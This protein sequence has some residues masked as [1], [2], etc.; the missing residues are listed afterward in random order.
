M[1]EDFLHYL[2]RLRRFD[3]N[4][5]QT[6]QGETIEIQKVG[7]H[8]IH[9]G[10][11]FTNARIRI[12]DTLWAGNV[13]I[14]LLASEWLKHHHQ[15]NKAYD[16]VILHVVLEED[17][18]V[19]RNNGERIP[20]LELKKRIPSKLT[21]IYQKLLHNEH[22][23][24]CQHHFYEVSN[25]TKNL[26][27]NR[28]L[29]ERLEQK[30]EAIIQTLQL[31]KSDWAETFYQF[32]ARNFGVKVNAIPFELLAK[33]IPILTL[34]KHSNNL[35]QIEA[36][37][38][39]QAGFL[40]QDF[41]D[42]Y[43]QQ[44]KKEY[45]FLQKK[46]QLQPIK[47]ELWKLLRLRP[48]NFPTIRIAQF[49]TLFY[50]SKALFSKILE[51]EGVK[52]LEQLFQVKLSNYWQTHY[53]FDKKSK[54]RNKSLGQDTVHL[55]IINTIVPFLFAYSRHQSNDNYQ[56]KALYIL[57]NLPLEKNSIISQWK[58]LGL[59]INTAYQSQALL[60]LKNEYCNEKRCLECAIGNKILTG[61]T[62][63]E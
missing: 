55:I 11:D 30:T 14:H 23:I 10:P 58:L 44:L 26:W 34:A 22:W 3:S 50:Q 63:K 38:F 1:K 62:N 16:N 52:D 6:T 37:L 24:P 36:L 15:E 12:G 20:C 5:L 43:P 54:S 41:N 60:Q 19:Y 40:A 17:S 49:A 13:E 46:Y 61:T 28:L 57:D 42:S 39:G 8:N 29:V 56:D 53:V 18:P 25:L 9:A 21:N 45:L 59:E 51:A 4:N 31:N 7:D 2:W 47:K 27:L 35:I 32:L 48:A 33:S